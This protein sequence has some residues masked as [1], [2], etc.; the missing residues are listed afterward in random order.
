MNITASEYKDKNRDTGETHHRM[1][2]M[3]ALPDLGIQ[4]I[5]P[6]LIPGPIPLLCTLLA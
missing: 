6:K 3:A 2:G 1:S 5:K 4:A